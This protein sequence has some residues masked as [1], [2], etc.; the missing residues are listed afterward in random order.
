MKE[1]FMKMFNMSNETYD[2]LKLAA[3][4]IIPAI[5]TIYSALGMAFDW[6]YVAQVIAII[7]VTDT[8]L[9]VSLQLSSNQYHKESGVND[10]GQ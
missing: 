8:C 3:Q 2:K 5:G 9:G 7:T 10:D 1:K 4:I 6:P